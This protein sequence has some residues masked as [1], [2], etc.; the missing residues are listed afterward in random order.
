MSMS[1]CQQACLW[2]SQNLTFSKDRPYG[3]RDIAILVIF[4]MAAAAVL[5]F[6]KFGILWSVHG[7][8]RMC[9]SVPNFIKMCQTVAEMW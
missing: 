5:D 4:K 3:C 7:K 2:N 1:V 6:Q 9:A 8:G